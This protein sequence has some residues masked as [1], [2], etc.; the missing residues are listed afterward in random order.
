MCTYVR[1]CVHMV[2][3]KNNNKQ[4]KPTIDVSDQTDL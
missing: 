4:S 1:T 3:E 2:K